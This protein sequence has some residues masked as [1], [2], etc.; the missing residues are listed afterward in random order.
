MLN[1]NKMTSKDQAKKNLSLDEFGIIITKKDGVEKIIDP[2]SES[3]FIVISQNSDSYRSLK[4][5]IQD[6]IIYVI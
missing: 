1:S 3:S 2:H 4:D 5:K 6:K